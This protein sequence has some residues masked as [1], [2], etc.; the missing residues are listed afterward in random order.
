MMIL[1]PKA[2]G[3]SKIAENLA[4]RTNMTHINFDDFVKQND[5]SNEDD[6][7]VTM[8]LIKR[9]STELMPRVILENFPQNEFQAKFFIR[10][11][12]QPSNVFSLECSKDVCQERMIEIGETNPKYVSSAILSQKIK[13]Y[14]QTAKDL[15]PYVKANTPFVSINTDRAFDK[16]MDDIN[17]QIEPCVIHIRPGAN[18]NILRKEITEKLS[19]LHNFVDLDIN[20]LIRDENE[21]KTAIGIEMHQMV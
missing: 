9:L 16:V 1:G 21:R 11:C 8:A 14:Y 18:S 13:A 15:L 7:T 19:S 12:K 3:K 5:F 6:E 20:G 17:R 4:E 10:N 2:S